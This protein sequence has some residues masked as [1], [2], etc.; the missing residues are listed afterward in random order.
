MACAAAGVREVMIMPPV[1]ARSL[2]SRSV[3]AGNDRLGFGK[4]PAEWHA[5]E[6]TPD[7]RDIV[8]IIFGRA[9]FELVDMC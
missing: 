6:C 5:V 9:A 1:V 2:R 7:T 8:S 4:V 3:N